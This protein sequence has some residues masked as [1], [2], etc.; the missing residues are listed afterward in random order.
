MLRENDIRTLSLPNGI[1]FFLIV[2]LFIQVRCSIVFV[3]YLGGIFRLANLRSDP[4]CISILLLASYQL[5]SCQGGYLVLCV[6]ISK[7]FAVSSGL[8]PRLEEVSIAVNLRYRS[9]HFACMILQIESTRCERFFVV[10]VVSAR[11]S[12]KIDLIRFERLMAQS[13]TSANLSQ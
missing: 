2:M 12:R 3:T 10:S 11:Q 4:S 8:F 5:L 6:V 9:F 13:T 7:F 1:G